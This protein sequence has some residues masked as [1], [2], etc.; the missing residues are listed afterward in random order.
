VAG[1]DYTGLVI[2]EADK[3]ITVTTA[4]GREVSHQRYYASKQSSF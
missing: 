1:E 4:D 3:V 2:R